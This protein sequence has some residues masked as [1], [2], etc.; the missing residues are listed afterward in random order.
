MR[1]WKSAAAA[2]KSIEL[3]KHGTLK[4]YEGAPHGIFGDYQR[5]LDR[6]ILEF[7]KG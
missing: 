5:Q 4:V 1:A 2:L 7:I 6:D 3:V